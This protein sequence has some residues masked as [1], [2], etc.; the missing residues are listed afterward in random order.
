MYKFVFITLA[1]IASSLFDQLKAQLNDTE[2]NHSIDKLYQEM[3]PK[4]RLFIT[5]SHIISYV[6]LKKMD[7]ISQE[8]NQKKHYCHLINDYLM[9]G[10]QTLQKKGLD[11]KQAILVTTSHLQFIANKFF[12]IKS[13]LMIQSNGYNFE[14][15]KQHQQ[16][17]T[18]FFEALNCT[19]KEENPLQ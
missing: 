7:S 6:L 5:T 12:S 10:V 15:I 11:Q 3:T 4:D 13:M 16:N 14:A 1:I 18:I 9:T 8:P 17:R 2:A 19:L